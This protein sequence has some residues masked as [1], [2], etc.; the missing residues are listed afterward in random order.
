MRGLVEER[1]REGAWVVD[2]NYSKLRDIVWARADT[3]VWLDYGFPR[4]FGQLLWRT[5]R[6][7]VTGEELWQ[8]NRE[9]F[10]RAFFLRDSI[11][12]WAIRTHRRRRRLYPRLLARPENAHLR[13]VRLRSPRDA[14]RWL[15]RLSARS[16]P[17]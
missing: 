15:A 3:V 1:T 7:S 12:L 16:H 6:R 11:L 14:R 17:V 5:I 2:G 13:L 10:R 4:A 8:G 9:S